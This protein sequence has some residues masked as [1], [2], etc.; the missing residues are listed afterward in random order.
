MAIK[1]QSSLNEIDVEMGNILLKEMKIA[2]PRNIEKTTKPLWGPDNVILVD[3]LE[4]EEIFRAWLIKNEAK[5]VD[6][7]Y[8]ILAYA[9]NDID[10]VFYGTGNRVHQWEFQTEVTDDSWA[11]GD[12]VWVIDGFYRGDQGEIV[13]ID[14]D[15][16]IHTYLKQEE[17]K[18]AF[19]VVFIDKERDI[20]KI[21][22]LTKKASENKNNYNI[23]VKHID[24]IKRESASHR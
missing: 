18:N 19:L 21:N 14:K 5:K 13:S 24:C 10:E 8:P 15:K 16:Q 23:F 22:K 2:D 6:V 11:V 1:I 12:T 3:E 4:I 20:D 7:Q 9:P 17:C